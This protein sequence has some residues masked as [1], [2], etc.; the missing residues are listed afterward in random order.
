VVV[1][2]GSTDGTADWVAEQK[3]PFAFRLFR[4]ANAGPSSSRNVGI[5]AAQGDILIFL[6]DDLVPAPEFVAE[7]LRSHAAEERVAVIG[8]AV[9]LPR[10]RQPWIAWQQAT[11]E[12]KYRAMAQGWIEPT[13]QHFW[14]GNCSVPRWD[15]AAVGGFNECLRSGEDVELGCRLMRRGLR[16]RFNPAARGY[17][18]SVR[19]LAVWMQGCSTQG[20]LEGQVLG[21]LGTAEMDKVLADE[22]Q[23]RHQ[24]TRSLVR[25]STGQPARTAAAKLVLSGCIRLGTIAPKSAFSRAACAAMAN[26]LYWDGLAQS[27]GGGRSLF[28]RLDA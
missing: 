8:P 17:H 27:L 22:W 20:R 18:H 13:Y 14:S 5:E 26:L 15:I 9:S 19:P 23:S 24:L 21:Q 25:W 6:D 10:Y 28:S 16:F 1:D 7:H 3:F 4:Q 12:R 11:F 2:D